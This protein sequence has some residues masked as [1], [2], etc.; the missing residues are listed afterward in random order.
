MDIIA[1]FCVVLMM[2]FITLLLILVLFIFCWMIW[3]LFFKPTFTPQN[4]LKCNII[5]FSCKNVLNISLLLKIQKK[6]P[7]SK[8]HLCFTDT[9]L[10]DNLDIVREIFEINRNCDRNIIIYNTDLNFQINMSKFLN[11]HLKTTECDIVPFQITEVK[12]LIDFL[13]SE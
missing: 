6:L 10:N 13:Y 1:I 12:D 9:P 7:K 11:E 2:N 5:L 8:I 4:K 3:F